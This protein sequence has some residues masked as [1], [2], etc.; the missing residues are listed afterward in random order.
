MIEAVFLSEPRRAGWGLFG[1]AAGVCLYFIIVNAF[2]ESGLG[3]RKSVATTLFVSL[4]LIGLFCE[5]AYHVL[6]GR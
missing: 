1:L 4:I 6:T 3:P 2:R 5:A